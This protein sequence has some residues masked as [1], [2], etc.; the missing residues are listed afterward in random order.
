M[1]ALKPVL[2]APEAGRAALIVLSRPSRSDRNGQILG[3]TMAGKSKLIPP[4]LP[5][6]FEDR[7]PAEIAAMNAMIEKIRGVYERY[8][9]D[10][11]ETPLFEY[12]EALGKFLPD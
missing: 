7:E 10:S 6:G 9:F 1:E 3:S 4:R 5:R 12:T 8:G 2:P 11:V